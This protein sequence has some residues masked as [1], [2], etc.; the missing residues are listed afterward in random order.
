MKNV[1]LYIIFNL[2]ILKIKEWVNCESNKNFHKL[3]QLK[4]KEAL[5]ESFY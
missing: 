5:K 3:K 1:F 4:D 2:N